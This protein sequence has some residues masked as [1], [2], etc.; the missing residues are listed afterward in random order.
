MTTNVCLQ[1]SLVVHFTSQLMVLG[2]WRSANRSLVRFLCKSQALKIPLKTQEKHKRLNTARDSD[3]FMTANE[4]QTVYWSCEGQ[5]SRLR[6]YNKTKMLMVTTESAT[7]SHEDLCYLE[8]TDLHLE[9]WLRA[10]LTLTL[11]IEQPPQ[12]SHSLVLTVKNRNCWL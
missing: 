7:F 9:D 11:M 1:N 6:Q 3:C 5:S 2:W 4:K 10:C 12:H 8:N